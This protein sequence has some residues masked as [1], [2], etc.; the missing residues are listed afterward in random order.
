MKTCLSF[1]VSDLYRFFECCCR[2]NWIW[3]SASD[4]NLPCK[5]EGKKSHP[6]LLLVLFSQSP[7]FFFFFWKVHKSFSAVL[8]QELSFMTK[9]DFE[10][11]CLSMALGSFFP[12]HFSLFLC[13]CGKCVHVC[14]SSGPLAIFM[15]FPFH[16]FKFHGI[17]QWLL[18][19]R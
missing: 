10:Y 6:S 7:F 5:M 4:C 3:C 12:P 13:L 11:E 14:F 18:N 19:S 15:I 1:F 16:F 17:F 2:T 9:K 8:L